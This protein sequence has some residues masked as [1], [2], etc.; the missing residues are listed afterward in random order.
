MEK[1]NYS[2]FGGVSHLSKV[3]KKLKANNWE[4]MIGVVF[5]T[6]HVH[7]M[8]KEAFFA[9]LKRYEEEPATSPKKAEYKE[10]FKAAQIDA[11]F[12]KGFTYKA[13]DVGVYL[14]EPGMM[15]KVSMV[16]L[17]I[18]NS[19][20]ARPLVTS[21]D[22]LSKY[23]YPLNF[24]AYTTM[25]STPENPRLRV[26][27]PTDKN[28]P[29]TAY[30]G[31]V[32]YVASKLGI[33][34]T[35]DDPASTQLNHNFKVPVVFKDTDTDIDHPVIASRSSGVYLNTEVLQGMMPR[36][37]AETVDT[38]L[39]KMD[40]KREKLLGFTIE[41]ATEALG[42]LDIADD[43]A[44]W[45]KIGMLLK[46]QFG[47]SNEAFDLFHKWSQVG[48]GKSKYSGEQDCRATWN[49][50]SENP[51]DRIPVTA[52]T[53]VQM[54]VLAGW[55]YKKAVQASQEAVVSWLRDPKRTKEELIGEGMRKIV[56]IPIITRLEKDVIIEEIRLALKAK[57]SAIGKPSLV[58]EYDRLTRSAE[59]SYIESINA[60]NESDI[61]KWARGWIYVA[62]TGEEGIIDQFYHYACDRR[63]NRSTLDATYSVF[64]TQQGTD[65]KNPD[66]TPVPVVRPSDYLLQGIRIPRVDGFRY[67]PDIDDKI[68]ELDNKRYVN[69]YRKSYPQ[70]NL[71][72]AE[73]AGVLLK[74]HLKAL[75]GNDDIER[76]YLDFH[77]YIVQ[78]PGKKINWMPI[79]QGTK[80]AGKS[81]MHRIMVQC[82]GV[83]NCKSLKGEDL[84]ND[85]NT[86]W[87]EGAQW[88]CIEE[89]R[90]PGHNRMAVAEKLKPYITDAYIGIRKMY[91]DNYTIE[92]VTNYGGTTNHTEPIHVDSDERRYF[93][94]NSV[95]QCR[96]DK[97]ALVA[98]GHYGELYGMLN[99]HPG[100]YRAFLLHHKISD[101]FNPYGDAP[102]TEAFKTLVSEGRSEIQMLVDDVIDS[103]DT[104]LTKR[105]FLVENML[106][107]VQQAC[108]TQ[109]VK[110]D[111]VNAI[112]ALGFVNIMQGT[113]DPR[114]TLGSNRFLVYAHK[115][116]LK[117]KLA[118][119]AKE[120]EQ[121]IRQSEAAGNPQAFKLRTPKL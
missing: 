42:F 76:R 88:V 31:L 103:G 116:E 24:V 6:P 64:L 30:I 98:S 21:P 73:A 75:I 67:R 87:A 22:N 13:N 78:N 114:V 56:S 65:I 45:I 89:M 117:D 32:R 63:Y 95:L 7:K 48:R 113:T 101:D 26:I 84:I 118:P 1:D 11:P 4:E 91:T 41:H 115:S 92:N 96:E 2:Y 59:K 104:T 121:A 66:A 61:P 35:D 82:L 23:L 14:G 52:A 33:S 9:L 57:G 28:V 94:I 25:R 19:A 49:S 51:T 85:R 58:R 53:L 86:A 3:L 90:M 43:R 27:V 109:Y 69:S 74:K 39:L 54:A 36:I 46:H 38:K 70:E 119:T 47:N 83:T 68:I 71:E 111:V 77:A 112:R 107:R 120:I 34:I 16:I 40:N 62:G 72:Y 29:T 50:F 20:Q 80:G 105:I 93:I 44:E 60:V 37:T 79:I 106:Q 55:D 5:N 18:D 10:A 99:D 100:A 81:S 17:D 12:L 97:E 108:R 15:E 8:G 110:K 102:V